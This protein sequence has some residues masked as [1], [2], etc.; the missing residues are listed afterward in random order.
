MKRLRLL[1][2]AKSSWD[3]P[4]LDDVDRPLARRGRKAT[5]RLAGWIEEHEV[6]PDLVVCSPAVRARETIESLLAALGAPQVLVDDHLYHASADELLIR[7]HELADTLGDVLL[8]GHNP[9]LADL[10]LAL[11]RPGALRD[12]VAAKLPTGALVTLVVDAQQW[13]E[14]APGTA[15]LVELVLPR[16]LG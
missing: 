8:V 2:H 10:S 15:D 16:E 13:S 6:R 5:R 1:R 7:V 3:Q 11:A 9:G 4:A 14:L 12:R